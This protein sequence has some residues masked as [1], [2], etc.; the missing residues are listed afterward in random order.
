MRAQKKP[1][2]ILSCPF[3]FHF[4][5]AFVLQSAG[6]YLFASRTTS[7]LLLLG[8]GIPGC[9]IHHIMLTSHWRQR[10]NP[11][12]FSAPRDSYQPACFLHQ[13]DP[14]EHLR[15]RPQGRSQVWAKGAQEE[16]TTR[17]ESFQ[18]VVSSRFKP[19]LALLP[20][21]FYLH[22]AKKLLG[23]IKEFAHPPT[24]YP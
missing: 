9:L 1:N 3:V 2:S 23:L 16:A 12:P 22:Q 6:F 11:S 19:F 4:I 5:P 20:Q 15:P 24:E 8:L 21:G 18:L 17:A 13:Q 14:R 10:S 7:F